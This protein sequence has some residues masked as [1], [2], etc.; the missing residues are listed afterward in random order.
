MAIFLPK[1]IYRLDAILIKI[2]KQCFKEIYQIQEHIKTII[3]HDQVD[4][5]SVMQGWLNIQQSINI[6][7][8]INRE[9]EILNIMWKNKKLRIAKPIPSYKSTSGK[10]IIPYLKGLSVDGIELKTQK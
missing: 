8:Y 1:I 5:T 10:I 4:F 7:H 9:R 3:Y 6:I 2:P